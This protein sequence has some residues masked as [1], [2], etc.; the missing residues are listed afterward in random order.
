MSILISTIFTFSS[1][2]KN[3]EITAIKASGISIRRIGMPILII[4]TILCIFSFYFD[5]TIVTKSIN[6][7]ADIEKKFKPSKSKYAKTKKNDIYYS[8]KNSILEIKRFN[9]KNDTGYDISLQKFMNQ[10][11]I[12]RFDAKKMTWNNQEKYWDFNNCHIRTWKNNK[13]KYSFISD[14]SFAITDIFPEIIKKDTVKPEE[15]DYWELSLFISK[16]KDKGLDYTRWLVNKHYK[17]AFACIP[18]IMVVFGLALS[19]SKPRSNHAIGFG[20]SIIVIFLYYALILFGRTL[21]Y[22]NVLPPFLSV[23]IVNFLFFGIGMYIFI[24]ART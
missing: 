4:G 8:L 9:Y 7:R 6:K 23:W 12:Y 17:I 15:M 22:N 18:F 2:Q 19:I 21:G 14:T 20:L 1:L 3:N 11:I 16:L 5:N 24:K 10:D 13:Y